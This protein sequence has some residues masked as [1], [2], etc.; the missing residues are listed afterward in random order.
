[1]LRTNSLRIITVSLACAAGLMAQDYPR[2][3]T[4]R[5]S[6]DGTSGAVSPNNDAQGGV[7][8]GAPYQAQPPQFGQGQPPQF[9][10]PPPPPNGAYGPNYGP[11][12]NV[13]ATLTLQSGA[14]LTVRVNQ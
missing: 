7:A 14:S 4:V 10:D 11:A 5:D 2:V 3:L 12:A 13:P 1:M 8:Q 9:N 6:G